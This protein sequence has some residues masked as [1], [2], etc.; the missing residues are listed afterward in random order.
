MRLALRAG[1]HFRSKG[2]QERISLRDVWTIRYGKSMGPRASMMVEMGE[3]GDKLFR[4]HVR[5]L[6]VG[7]EWKVEW[8]SLKVDSLGTADGGEVVLEL[9]GVEEAR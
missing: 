4:K 3:P 7:E 2:G 5:D 8:M 1:E 6:A 9:G